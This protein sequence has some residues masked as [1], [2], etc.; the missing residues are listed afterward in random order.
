MSYALDTRRARRVRPHSLHGLGCGCAMPMAGLGELV[1]P[2]T[3]LWSPL[4]IRAWL[5]QINEQIRTLGNDISTHRA[6]ITSTSAGTR[7]I[8]DFDEFRTRWLRFNSTAETFWGSTVDAAQEY[9]NAYNALERRFRT[10]SGAS[11][12]VYSELSER[13]TPNAIRDANYALMGWAVIGIAGL[14]AAGY[15][16]S[17]YARIKTVS[18]L[19]FNRRRRRRSRR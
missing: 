17:N 9:V 8:A 16:L 12:T 10:V 15:L 3:W 13:E 19:S 1:T 11:P 6:R 4:A 18:K 2:T 7:F 14:A 5:N